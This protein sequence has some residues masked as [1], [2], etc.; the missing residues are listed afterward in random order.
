MTDYKEIIKRLEQQNT[1]P[2]TTE[3][4]REANIFRI[5]W[6]K[7]LNKEKPSCTTTIFYDAVQQ[8]LAHGYS[9]T[10]NGLLQD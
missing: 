6:L 10:P 2:D 5:E 4:Q 7:R 9:I 8:R 3:A 1:L